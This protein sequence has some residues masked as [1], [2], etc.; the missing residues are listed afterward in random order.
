MEK[1]GGEGDEG[2]PGTWLKCSSLPNLP[3]YSEKQQE[4]CRRQED[5]ADR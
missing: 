2:P 5:A 1:V 4:G 3:L